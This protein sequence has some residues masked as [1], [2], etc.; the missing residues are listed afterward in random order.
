MPALRRSPAGRRI[1]LLGG[2]FNPA[3][4]GHMHVSERALERL[5]LDE[6]WWLVSPQNPLKPSA[7]MAP[8]RVRL[9]AARK[10]A[11]GPR[12][13]ATD[14][15][16]RLGTRYAVDT[17]ESLFAEFPDDRFVWI[18]G[19]DNLIQAHR[20]KN[21]RRMFRML[22]IAVFA[23]PSYCLRALTAKAARRF[24]RARVRASRAGDVVAMQ[25]P[26]WVFLR[27]RL[28]AASATQIRARREKRGY[29]QTD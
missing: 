5:R 12:V 23:R 18:M 2:S 13:K 17:L 27:E 25:P 3:H 8:L 10:L 1:G 29:G 6:V 4:G 16:R 7:G 28:H 22:P 15:E 19:A 20:W 11:T 14:I 21:W 26:A 24:A 9:A